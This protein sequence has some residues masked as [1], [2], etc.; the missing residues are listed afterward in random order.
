VR[1]SP[2][3]SDCETGDTVTALPAAASTFL[4]AVG[5]GEGVADVDGDGLLDADAEGVP[6]GVAVG[7]GSAAAGNGVS[8]IAAAHNDA[9]NAGLIAGRLLVNAARHGLHGRTDA[10]AGQ[11]PASA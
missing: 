3:G 2:A 9:N 5:A 11:R 4:V 10:D 7:D 8:T 1:L 6:V